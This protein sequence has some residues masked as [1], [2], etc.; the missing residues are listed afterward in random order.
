MIKNILTSTLTAIIISTLALSF[1]PA[2]NQTSGNKSVLGNQVETVLVWLG[3]GVRV[4][5]LGNNVTK[6]IASTCNLIIGKTSQTGSTTIP[7][8]C[9]INGV[10][11]NDTIIAQLA[12]STVG[13]TIL[14]WSIGS[15][16]ASTTPNYVTV[17]LENRTG[18][19]ANPSA[20]SV[21]SS[22][23]IYIL[24]N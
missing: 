8:D 6:V 12:T 3:G 4:G 11:T 7:Y 13:S 9:Q 5:N 15:A 17:F 21:G 22:T 1:I 24:D 2:K 14:G 18:T 19:S 23:R 16:K 20:T 10:R